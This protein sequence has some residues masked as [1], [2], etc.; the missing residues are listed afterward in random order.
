VTEPVIK[1]G[2]PALTAGNWRTS[3]GGTVKNQKTKV[4]VIYEDGKENLE[5][6]AKQ[7]KSSL[8]NRASVK[9]RSATEVALAEILAA[10]AYAFGVDDA[11]AHAWTE[12][13][14]LFKGIHLA[15]RK[16]GFFTSSKDGANRL[17]KNFRDA[18]LKLLASDLL[19]GDPKETESWVDALVSSN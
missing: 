17:K 9:T 13:N 8:G 16:A 19:A 18:E 7:V 15:G 6:T 11:D 4:L 10:D 12:F 2:K 14:R 5:T 3:I 1:P